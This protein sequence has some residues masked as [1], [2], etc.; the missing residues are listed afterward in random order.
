MLRSLLI[1]ATVTAFAI[2]IA[3]AGTF[4]GQVKSIDVKG[5]IVTLGDG[6]TYQLAP[7]VKVDALKAG[8]SVTVSYDKLGTKSV[9]TK[10]EPAKSK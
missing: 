7:G 2:G 3:S 1:A 6:K 5:R 4:S 9:I 8:Q 10:I